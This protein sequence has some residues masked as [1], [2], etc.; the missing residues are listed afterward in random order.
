MFNDKLILVENNFIKI[1]NLSDKSS[2]F[3]SRKSKNIEYTKDLSDN[4]IVD[5][6]QS[7]LSFCKKFVKPY[8]CFYV[9]K[10]YFYDSRAKLSFNKESII[11]SKPVIISLL[12]VLNV[13][14]QDIDVSLA[15][16]QKRKSTSPKVT[17][18]LS[19]FNDKLDNKVIFFNSSEFT[20]YDLENNILTRMKLLRYEEGIHFDTTGVSIYNRILNL[21]SI[22]TLNDFIRIIKGSDTYIVSDRYKESYYAEEE[23]ELLK[24]NIP[25][26]LNEHK[27]TLK[28]K[29]NL[30]NLGI[31]FL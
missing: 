27:K 19:T 10:N 16:I 6:I 28:P 11:N 30:L 21:S 26:L 29:T 9:Y 22:N 15:K 17:K 13:V 18:F 7:H 12:P 4:F 31:K 20:L 8:S 2:I 1:I 23:I 3:I 14:Y 24:T 5:I 25:L